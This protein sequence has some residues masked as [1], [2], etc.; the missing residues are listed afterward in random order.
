MKIE[1]FANEQVER[2]GNRLWV[3]VD[4][5][6]FMIDGIP[7]WI[8]P[9]FVTDGASVPRLLWPICSPMSGP[10]GQPSIPH[11]FFYCHKGPDV[12]R[13]YADYV[14]YKWGRMR[15]SGIIK[16]QAV[17]TTLNICGWACYKTGRDKVT[18]GKCYNLEYAKLRV[19]QL[20]PEGNVTTPA[21]PYV[22]T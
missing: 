12:G 17:K 11:D 3:L 5:F 15:G 20:T 4:W 6:G 19:E 8:P 2:L 21:T 13:L 16:A 1:V 7:Y 22:L 9:G 14:L 18:A 10:F